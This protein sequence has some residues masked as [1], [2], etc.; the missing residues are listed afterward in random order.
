MKLLLP[1][2]FISFAEF[3]SASLVGAAPAAPVQK[4]SLAPKV[5]PKVAPKTPPKVAPQPKA[6]I[7]V[8]PAKKLEVPIVPQPVARPVVQ[9]AK[10]QAAIPSEEEIIWQ[11]IKQGDMAKFRSMLR[12]SELQDADLIGPWHLVASINFNFARAKSPVALTEVATRNIRVDELVSKY[13]KP[14]VTSAELATFKNE[15]QN[16]GGTFAAARFFKTGNFSG[17]SQDGTITGGGDSTVWRNLGQNQLRLQWKVTTYYEG[18]F[19]ND[20]E[21]VTRDK[22]NMVY[23][24]RVGRYLF[25]APTVGSDNWDVYA[26]NILTDDEKFVDSD[27][28]R[29]LQIEQFRSKAR[30][31]TEQELRDA[32]KEADTTLE[33]I[34]VSEDQAKR[35]QSWHDDYYNPNPEQKDGD[36]ARI[37]VPQFPFI[38]T[39]SL[40]LLQTETTERI[41]KVEAVS[42]GDGSLLLLPIVGKR[43]SSFPLKAMRAFRIGNENEILLQR[44]K[45]LPVPISKFKRQ[46]ESVPLLMGNRYQT[47]KQT[48]NL[49]G[50]S[51]TQ[52]KVE[53]GDRVQITAT[54]EVR[55]GSFAGGGGPNGIR[56][57]TGYNNFVNINHGSLIGKIENDAREKW[58]LVGDGV[59]FTAKSSGSLVLAV[60]DT[61]TSNNSGGFEVTISVYRPTKAAQ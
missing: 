25:A 30:P 40:D 53:P 18:D 54:G 10:P 22:S 6:P 9:D 51:G 46:Q 1:L 3:S 16:I 32:L 43:A 23:V 4:P 49:T 35:E 27:V 28:L 20:D 17:S 7:A 29:T 19:F 38:L 33:L 11:A 13:A 56:F 37:L 39:P 15:L 57:G 47:Q 5:A 2:L 21:Y 61:D 52:I 31:V 34:E 41:G 8:A 12:A 26:Y 50:Y 59:V 48:V 58:F 44:N 42:L 14:Y 45:G 55:F 36:F 24:N 60:N